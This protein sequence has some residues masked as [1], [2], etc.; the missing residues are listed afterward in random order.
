MMPAIRSLSIALASRQQLSPMTTIS[1]RVRARLFT[2]SMT[3]R[4]R[5]PRSPLQSLVRQPVS[6]LVKRVTSWLRSSLIHFSS[7]QHVKLATLVVMSIGERIS[8]WSMSMI[9]ISQSVLISIRASITPHSWQLRWSGQSTQPMVMIASSR[10]SRMS[11][12][13]SHLISSALVQMELSQT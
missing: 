9:L 2:N 11:M 12:T 5:C 7:R 1:L 8:F 4:P 3:C 13:P 10:L 6:T